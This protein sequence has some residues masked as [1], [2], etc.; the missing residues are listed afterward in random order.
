MEG[1]EWLY[2]TGHRGSRGG[3]WGPRIWGTYK[4][5]V[6]LIKPA[7]GIKPGRGSSLTLVAGV[8]GGMMRGA[9]SQLP[10]RHVMCHCSSGWKRVERPRLDG[11]RTALERG[12]RILFGIDEVSWLWI[13][14][15]LT[16][17]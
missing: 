8:G 4:V 16:S 7:S 14:E 13:C 6:W 5:E 10:R 9:C 17:D 15:L 12:T 11:M 2:Y 1:R 3:W